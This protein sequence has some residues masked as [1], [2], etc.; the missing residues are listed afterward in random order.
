MFAN[1]KMRIAVG[2]C[3]I[4]AS[5]AIAS[6]AMASGGT[7]GPSSSNPTGSATYGPTGTGGITPD[8]GWVCNVTMSNASWKD[9]GGDYGGVYVYGTQTCTGTNYSPMRVGTSIWND[10]NDTLV[11]GWNWSPWTG[12]SSTSKNS[13]LVCDNNQDL[14]NFIGIAEGEAVDGE[15]YQFVQSGNATLSACGY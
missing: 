1:R 7:A 13:E 12:S 9:S 3:L 11:A 5:L 6:V 14:H 10:D 8:T 2:V 15:A 4:P